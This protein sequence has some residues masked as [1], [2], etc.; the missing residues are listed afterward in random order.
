VTAKSRYIFASCPDDRVGWLGKEDVKE[1]ERS[2]TI[3]GV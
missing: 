2:G 1:R 3:E